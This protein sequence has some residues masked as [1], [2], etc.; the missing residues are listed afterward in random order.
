MVEDVDCGV[1]IYVVSWDEEEVEKA[2]SKEVQHIM[3]LARDQGC[4][5]LHFDADGVVYPELP[6]FDW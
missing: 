5:W 3:R 1:M 4:K 2:L 6:Q